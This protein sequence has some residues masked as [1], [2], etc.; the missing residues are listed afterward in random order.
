MT[1]KLFHGFLAVLLCVI[2]SVGAASAAG[3]EHLNDGADL[4]TPAEEQ[5]LI[6]K[7]EQ[8]SAAYSAQVL[9]VTVPS[10][11]GS[12]DRLV[13]EIY[14]ENGY[15]YGENRDGV[16]LLVC[17]DPR[18]Y[19]ILSNGYASEAIDPDT[20]DM[21]SDLFVSDLSDGYF[22]DAFDT[23]ADECDYYLNGYLNGFPFEPGITLFLCLAFGFVI[24]LIVTLVMRMQLKSVRGQDQANLYIK[25]GSMH[26]T[27]SHDFF[28]YRNVTR[29]E[30]PQ[31]SKSSGS[32]SGGGRSVGGGKF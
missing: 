6:G 16:L 4:L 23:F 20:I 1:K 15:G 5:E 13:N 11:S 27:R 29:Q 26:L 2:L 30:K 17:M 24:A 7:L 14:D 18:E 21:I 12:V 32:R 31:Q 28:L 9:V 8:I 22:F 25:E 3:A 19:R 10:A